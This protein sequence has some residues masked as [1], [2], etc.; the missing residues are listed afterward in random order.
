MLDLL[1]PKRCAGCGVGPRPFCDECR[2]TVVSIEPPLCARCGAPTEFAKDH[3]A[4]CPPPPL[5]TVRAPFLFE[6]AVRRAVHRLKFAGD[7]S[8]AEALGE[9]MAGAN[10]V[11]PDVVTWVPLARG[12]RA[13]R[14][15]DQARAL[16]RVSAPRIGRPAVALLARGSEGDP[17]ARRS[18]AERRRAIRGAFRCGGRPPPHVLLVDDVLT[19]G[20]TAAECARVLLDAGA[21]HIDV[22]VAARA[23]TVRYPR[24]GS[25]PG[26][27][28]P[29]ETPR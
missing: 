12:R 5:V 23:I 3:C 29:G 14:G 27:W 26:L 24:V 7:R 22:L 18:G 15:F 10:L 13:R 1:F 4:D 16:A 21:R 17:Q 20:A 11:E 9:A 6:G 25:R 28:L 19:T 2:R 8:V